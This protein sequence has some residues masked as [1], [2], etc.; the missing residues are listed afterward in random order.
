[1]PYAFLVVSDRTRFVP[2]YLAPPPFRALLQVGGTTALEKMLQT[3][4]RISRLV[5]QIITT[6]EVPV[7]RALGSRWSTPMHSA[8][9]NPVEMIREAVHDLPEDDIVLFMPGDLPFISKT[10]VEEL[11]KLAAQEPGVVCPVVKTLTL[12]PGVKKKSLGFQEGELAPGYA[13]AAHRRVLTTE[14]FQRIDQVVQGPAQLLKNIGG[15]FLLKMLFSKPHLGEAQELAAYHLGVPVRLVI[16][17]SAGFAR[18][19]STEEDLTAA[20]VL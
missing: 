4:G 16:M 20:G 19:L 10:E 12:P 18:N 14:L 9:A 6:D 7:Q 2:E 3:L 11:L 15:R 17:P 13:L 1:M 5:T 8:Q